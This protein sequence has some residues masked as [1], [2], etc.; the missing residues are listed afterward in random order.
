[1]TDGSQGLRKLDTA[2]SSAR[3]RLAE[4]SSTADADARALAQAQDREA[5]ALA[6]IAE[7]RMAHLEQTPPSEADRP[8]AR[9]AR[10]DADV[11]DLI[12]AHGAHVSGLNAKRDAVEARLTRLEDGRRRADGKR[13]EAVSAHDTAAAESRRRL[14][15]NA[16]YQARA[17]AVDDANEIAERAARKVDIA[18]ADRR[19][20]GAAY[21]SDR[22]F[23]YLLERKYATSKYRA[24]PLFAMLDRWVARLISYRKWRATYVRLTELPEKL[25]AHADRVD[26]LAAE[27]EEA[28]EEMEREALDADG[29]DALRDRVGEFAREI[30]RLDAEIRDAEEERVAA[31]A[32]Y[33]AAAAGEAGPLAEARTML[34]DAVAAMNV[35]ALEELATQTASREDDRIVRELVRIRRER[36]EL[37]ESQRTAGRRLDADGRALQ[38][39]E[40]VRQRYKLSRFD[41][42]YSYFSGRDPITS[43]LAAFLR[44]ALSGDDLWRRIE[45]AHRTRRR[46]WD[47][48]VGGD[49]WR[50]GFGLPKRW[51]DDGWSG[52]PIGPSGPRWGGGA[53][54]RVRRAPTRIRVPRA[55]RRSSGGGF[56]TGGG[57]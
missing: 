31:Q 47:R 30:E 22:L 39:L 49:V 41:S 29:V 1:M 27:A 18:E 42:P 7:V 44:G 2:I 28:L 33:A 3:R 56:R 6:A 4:A 10:L 46:D 15:E 25:R 57:F 26:A 51:G 16:D 24:F 17:A 11:R 43:L 12:V 13:V 50:D 45:R 48:D 35:P 5:A 40:S 9:I 20:K 36:M 23:M 32:E 34:A 52:G 19:E 21:E 14:E 37:E 55:P 53:R 8:T 54:R 38:T